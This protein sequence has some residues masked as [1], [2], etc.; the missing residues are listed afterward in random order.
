MKKEVTP[1]I[2]KRL[3]DTLD[4]VCKYLAEEN[5]NEANKLQEEY[6][7][8]EDEY[9]LFDYTY[10]EDGKLGVKDITGKIRVPAIYSNYSELY[11]YTIK[12]NA[13]V[14]AQNEEGKFA[15]VTTDGK[16]TPLCNFKYD[17]IECKHYTSFYT[18]SKESDGRRFLGLLTA[19]GQELVPCEMDVIYGISNGI[20]V[21]EKDGKYGLVTSWGLYIPPIYNE[22]REDEQKFV[23]AELNGQWGHISG[24]GTFIPDEDE[25]TFDNTNCLSFGVDDLLD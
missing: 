11:S 20:I 23:H 25:D 22:L 13:P 5:Y 21:F 6:Y 7:K 12:R 2:I 19:K 9:N 17:M 8:I 14:A 4:A 15:L 3:N 16:G 10:E 24:E 1:E 18:C